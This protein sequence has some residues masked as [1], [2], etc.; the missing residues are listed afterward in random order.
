MGHVCNQFL[1][2]G[3]VWRRLLEENEMLYKLREEIYD[4]ANKQIAHIEPRLLRAECDSWQAP[5]TTVID[6]NDTD[7]KSYSQQNIVTESLQ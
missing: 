2:L 4:N 3:C 1:F 6:N 7:E 5:V